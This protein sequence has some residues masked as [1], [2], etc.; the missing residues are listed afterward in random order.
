MVGN[1]WSNTMSHDITVHR[2]RC[3]QSFRALKTTCKCRFSFSIRMVR[4]RKPAFETSPIYVTVFWTSVEDD[5]IAVQYRNVKTAVCRIASWQ[6]ITCCRDLR[7][8]KKIKTL[9][10]TENR[11]YSI[12][13][14]IADGLY[15]GV[16]RVSP[17]GRFRIG[18]SSEVSG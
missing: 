14:T 3:S 8:Q 7:V 9:P 4:C 12:C 17:F 6:S 1:H 10:R 5:E 15:S 2:Q 13:L 16:P 18:N 11:W